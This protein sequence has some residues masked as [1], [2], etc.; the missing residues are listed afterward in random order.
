M[1]EMTKLI[2]VLSDKI[3]RLE[4]GNKIVGPTPQNVG[5][6]N[7]KQNPRQANPIFQYRNQ[8]KN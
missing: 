5:K 4:M 6:R 3:T 1:E 7:P 8:N 2:R